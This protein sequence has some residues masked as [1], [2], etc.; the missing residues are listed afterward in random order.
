MLGLGVNGMRGWAV[1]EMGNQWVGGMRDGDCLG[2]R[3]R[4]ADEMG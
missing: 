1:A 3:L 2:M 4:S